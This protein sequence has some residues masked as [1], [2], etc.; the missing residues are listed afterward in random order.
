MLTT[1][2]FPPP[3]SLAIIMKL[4]QDPWGEIYQQH[5]EG[6]TNVRDESIISPSQI[7]SGH[8]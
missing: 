3:F 6:D 7:K 4:A 8:M 2:R 5:K 1:W